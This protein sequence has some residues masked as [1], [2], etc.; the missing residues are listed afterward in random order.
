MLFVCLKY[1]VLS[2]ALHNGSVARLIFCKRPFMVVSD[3]SLNLAVI[4]ET[5]RNTFSL[6]GEI[7][8]IAITFKPFGDN[9]RVTAFRNG[10]YI[11]A[12]VIVGQLT[13]YTE[14]YLIFNAYLVGDGS[15]SGYVQLTSAHDIY[16]GA[17]VG[18]IA[19][20]ITAVHRE[21]AG[22]VYQN[23]AASS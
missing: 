19:C 7:G 10:F 5:E 16:A 11:N 1:A 12:I 3:S 9:S 23:A 13:G 18:L 17:L 20:D 8:K 4:S 14:L 21:L 2:R 6:A 22:I 15:S